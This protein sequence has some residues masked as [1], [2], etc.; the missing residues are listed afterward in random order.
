MGQSQMIWIL[1]LVFLA[2]VGLTG[3]L[4]S[5]ALRRNLVDHPN[6]RSSHT[7]ATPRGGG[8][9]IVAVFLFAVL[10]SFLLERLS[11]EIFVAIFL[12]GT[13]V[14]GIGYWDDHGHVAPPWRLL[15]HFTAAGLALFSLG[16]FPTWQFGAFQVDMGWFGYVLGILFLVWLLNLYNFMDGIDG[17]AGS[18]AIFVAGGACVIGFGVLADPDAAQISLMMLQLVL[19]AASFGFLFWNWP[20]AKIFLGDVGSGFLGFVLG[21]LALYNAALGVLPLWSWLILLGV[22]LVDATVTLLRRMITGEPWYQAHH[23]HAY[24]HASRRWSSHK[25]VTSAIIAVNVVWLLPL[26]WLAA[27]FPE[28]GWFIAFFA[29]LPLVPLAVRLGAGTEKI[30]RVTTPPE[31][32]L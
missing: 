19:V 14:A 24:Q 27:V 8:L 25:R 5:F 16:G 32:H 26:A 22:F 18:E 29:L 21:V 9:V 10:V 30:I 15:V 3:F 6:E 28:N 12:G 1:G 17:I 23:C 13:M 20:P 4:R 11:L 7:V 31:D 2:S